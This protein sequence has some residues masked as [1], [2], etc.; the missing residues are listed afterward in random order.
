V[1]QSFSGRAKTKC[2]QSAGNPRKYLGRI[3][4]II[5][6]IS[7]GLIACEPV[8]ECQTDRQTDRQTGRQRRQEFCG[9]KWTHAA[10][11]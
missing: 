11:E 4:V 5:I 7:Y 9:T 10:Y 1:W 8:A 3:I 2:E 6:I